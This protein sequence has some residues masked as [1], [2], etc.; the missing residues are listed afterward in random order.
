MGD[1]AAKFMR[2]VEERTESASLALTP[3]MVYPGRRA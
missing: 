1:S 3:F 2:S